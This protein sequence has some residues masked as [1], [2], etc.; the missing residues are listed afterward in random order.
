MNNDRQFYLAG[1]TVA[2]EGFALIAGHE[3]IGI[4]EMPDVIVMVEYCDYEL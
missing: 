4:V 3:H 1:K 2:L